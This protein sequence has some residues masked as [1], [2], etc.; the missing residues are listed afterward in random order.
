MAGSTPI[1]EDSIRPDPGAH[2]TREE[3][4]LSPAERDLWIFRDGKKPVV[5]LEL[6][7][8]L[9]RLLRSATRDH[10]KV[11]DALILAGQLEAALAD[12]NSS[13]AHGVAQLTDRLA[14]ALGS[15]DAVE[16]NAFA[17]VE[18]LGVPKQ[19]EISPPEG[20][21]YYA[22]HPLD[23]ANLLS[24][25]P[26]ATQ[27]AVI[28]IRS[29]GATLSAVV[30]AGLKAQDKKTARITVRP[31]GHPYSRH[32]EFSAGQ[33]DWIQRNSKDSA[34]FLIVDE[35]P[36]RSGSTFLAVAEALLSAGVPRG[37]I[38]LLGSRQPELSSLCADNAAARWTSFR[39]LATTP[40][41]NTRFQDHVYVGG[42]D[43]R[44]YL[45]SNQSWPES[46][47]EMERLKFVSPDWQHLYKFEGM[48]SMGA[49]V[50]ERAFALAD[51]G[52]AP[53]VRDAGDGFLAYELLNGKRL[54]VGDVSTPL[55][56]R[57]AEYCAFRYQ[58]LG[59]PSSQPSQLRAML[60]FN[61]SQEF[62][63]T[64]DLPQDALSSERA[65]AVDGRMQPY[66][67]VFSNRLLK[68]DG[69][70]HGD[71]HFFPGPCDIAWDLAGTSVEWGLGA[72]ATAYL[73]ERFERLSGE[74]VSNRISVY[75]LAYCVFRLGFC[76]MAISTV[77]GTPEE[78]RLLAG[79]HRYRAEAEQSIE[80]HR[81]QHRCAA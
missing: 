69:V 24:R 21:T 18:G 63:V 39:F 75:R 51:A 42:G 4:A 40:S 19:V 67:W 34:Q 77:K 56:D 47:T 52:F 10:G 20:F 49:Q 78:A 68:T 37:N 11:L 46:W 25:V 28:G 30:V 43:W 81:L 13:A 54:G 31:T 41:I 26:A 59:T 38:T 58:N 32:L 62:G 74:T 33:F 36:G 12:A 53:M 17:T 65:I 45:L 35:G 16:E 73:L 29:I 9:R 1:S 3:T 8:E 6:L 5:A 15:G 50:R 71:N 44:R 55:L 22:L 76:K 70:D 14:A 7:D 57:F 64:V 79:Y 2:S 66:E 27:Y 72:E 80:S 61:V 48:G 23:F 60:E